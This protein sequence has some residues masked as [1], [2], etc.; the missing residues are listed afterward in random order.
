MDKT[1]R[2]NNNSSKEAM[3]KKWDPGPWRGTLGWD[4]GMGPWGGTL[5]WDPGMGPWGGTLW[6]DIRVKQ[7]RLFL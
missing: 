7:P 6:W 5:G 2:K 4:P 3:L 1:I